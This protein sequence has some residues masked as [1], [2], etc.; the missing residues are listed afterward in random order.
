MTTKKTY[1]DSIDTADSEQ[2]KATTMQGKSNEA[3][4][5]YEGAKIVS[6]ADTTNAMNVKIS[7]DTQK[8]YADL[9]SKAIAQQLIADDKAKIVVTAK[10]VMEETVEIVKKAKKTFKVKEEAK[11]DVEKLAVKK[12]K[13]ADDALVVAK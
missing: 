10:K 2:T 6:E 8:A 3:L 5:K 7:Q 4:A 13:I 1:N 11:I 9:Q 12:Q